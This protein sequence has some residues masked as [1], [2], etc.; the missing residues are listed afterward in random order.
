MESWT[1]GD[2]PAGNA[3]PTG[4]RGSRIPYAGLNADADRGDQFA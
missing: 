3:G 4:R 1:V 2:C